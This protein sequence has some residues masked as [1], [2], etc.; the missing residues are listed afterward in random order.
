MPELATMTLPGI[1]EVPLSNEQGEQYY[2]PG[3]DL[4]NLDEEKSK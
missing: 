3:T 1:G 4:Q 2:L